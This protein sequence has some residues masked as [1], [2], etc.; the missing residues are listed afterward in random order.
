MYRTERKAY[1]SI[2]L[3]KLK[4]RWVNGPVLCTPWVQNGSKG[5]ILNFSRFMPLKQP[6]RVHRTERNSY[7]SICPKKLNE[8][9]A[10]G[11]V[12]CTP[13]VVQNGS[14]SKNLNFS[15]FKPLKQPIRVHRTERKAYQ[16]IGLKKRNKT[17]GEPSCSMHSMGCSKWVER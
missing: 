9:W 2:C 3:K 5:K 4:K 12:L 1:Q 11:S 8:R 10:N 17:M 6:F 13:W 15:R 16:S 14:K 7:Q